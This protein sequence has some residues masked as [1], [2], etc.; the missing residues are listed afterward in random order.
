MRELQPD[1]GAQHDADHEGGEDEAEGKARA[2][3]TEDRS[4]EEDKDVHGGL[5]RGLDQSQLEDTPGLQDGL[6]AQPVGGGQVL[7]GKLLDQESA[8]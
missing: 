3:V 8:R 6:Q 4:P 2:V 5:G 7:P 1:L